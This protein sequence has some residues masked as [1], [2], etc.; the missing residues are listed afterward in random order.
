MKCYACACMYYI[1]LYFKSINNARES[2]EIKNKQCNL[3]PN[4]GKGGGAALRSTAGL[5]PCLSKPFQL[6]VGRLQS[7]VL[8]SPWQ[9]QYRASP[10][11]RGE[12]PAFPASPHTLGP[13]LAAAVCLWHVPPA[14]VLLRLWHTSVCFVRG[15]RT[16]QHVPQ[17]PGCLF[18]SPNVI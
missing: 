7:R 15:H 5:C 1:L 9:R 8:A 6:I 3:H 2:A 10:A 14:I 11:S 4:T 17:P 16:Q 12:P 18:S 13:G